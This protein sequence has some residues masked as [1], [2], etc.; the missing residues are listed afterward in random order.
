MGSGMTVKF[1]PLFFKHN[2]GFDPAA[3]QVIYTIVPVA[4]AL[5]SQSG[6]VVSKRLGRIPTILLMRGL[7]LGCLLLMIYAGIPP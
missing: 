5:F 6:T 7:G 4:M 1:F 2:C 3:V